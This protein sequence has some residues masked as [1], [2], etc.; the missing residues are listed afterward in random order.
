MG[1]VED[2]GD[3]SVRLNSE[4]IE[5]EGRDRIRFTAC[6]NSTVAKEI[7]R[8]TCFLHVV[9]LFSFHSFFSSL[10]MKLA[11]LSDTYSTHQSTMPTSLILFKIQQILEARN[12]ARWYRGRTNNQ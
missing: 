5:I 12:L 8:I 1:V 7:R 2:R 11:R 10:P 4:Q 9:Y 3:I 6:S